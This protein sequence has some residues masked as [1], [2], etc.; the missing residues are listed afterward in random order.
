MTFEQLEC[1]LAAANEST[2][3]EA[4]EHLHMTQSALSKQIMKLEKELQVTLFDRSKRHAVLT[5][6]GTLFAEDAAALLT[7]KNR[8]LHRLAQYR[9]ANDSSF[10]VGTLPILSQ[11]GLTSLFYAFSKEVPHCTIFCEEVEEAALLS[12]L[13]C[14]EFSFGILRDSMIPEGVYKTIPLAEDALMVVLPAAHPL[15][16]RPAL[17]L[18]DIAEEPF[19]LMQK[20]TAIYQLCLDLFSTYHHQPRL[21][22]TARMESILDAVSLGHGLSLLPQKS[23][24]LFQHA[25]LV[26]VPLM[27]APGLQIF[28]AWDKKKKLSDGEKLFLKFIKSQKL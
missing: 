11:Y 27:E 16:E 21:L 24:Q 13:E 2:F 14:G 12:G 19:F 7:S 23:F 28:L 20:H 17:S 1:F 8:V 9:Q 25:D 18:S 6:A 5:E 3:F 26:S 22:R 15:A 4:A 10:S